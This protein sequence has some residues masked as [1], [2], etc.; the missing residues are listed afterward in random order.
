M[1]SLLREY[2]ISSAEG[3]ALMRLAEALL[4]V[5][6]AETAIALTAD[7]LGRADFSA[8]DGEGPHRMLASLSASA[9]ALSK[10]LLPDSVQPPGLL[11]R[12]G[13]KTVVA[14]TVRAIQLL[15][16]QF[17]L[18]RRSAKRWPKPQLSAAPQAGLRFSFDMLGEG[19]RTEVTPNVTW[20]PT[21]TPSTRWP[22]RHRA[23]PDAGR[24]HLDQAERAVLALRRRA[25]RPCV[26]RAGARVCSG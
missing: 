8:H 7:Q 2:P 15:G 20:P 19:A 26:R 4:R 17:V 3:L 9:I 10:K 21:P 24:R 25:A 13:A 6:D 18:G 16:R 22:A 11:Q 12:L 1:E 23:H 5:P 14:A